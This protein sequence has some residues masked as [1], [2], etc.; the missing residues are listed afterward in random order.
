M[1][2]TTGGGSYWQNQQLG[3]T[4][5]CGGR[6]GRGAPTMASQEEPFPWLLL[7]PACLQ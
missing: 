3:P 4:G 1:S 6:A 7:Q 2:L 5:A